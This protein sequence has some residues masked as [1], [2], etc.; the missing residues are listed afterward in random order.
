[1]SVPWFFDEC[2]EFRETAPPKRF[3]VLG[4]RPE[5]LVIRFVE[6][7]VSLLTEIGRAAFPKDAEM[8][9]D[10]AKG[11]AELAGN[12]AGRL[13]FSP[14]DLVELAMCFTHL[15]TVWRGFVGWVPSPARKPC[16]R[17]RRW[18]G[19]SIM[20]LEDRPPERL[21]ERIID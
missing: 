9:G 6:V 16:R 14:E 4:E 2:F 8:L 15:D 1:M 19:A 20:V 10:S 3:Q 11:D 17:F 21:A 18:N 12:P 5:L 7:G 13:F